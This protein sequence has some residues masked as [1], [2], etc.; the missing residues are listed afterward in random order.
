MEIREL[1]STDLAVSQEFLDEA[2]ATSRIYVKKIYISKR[3]GGTRIVYQPSTKLKT[4]QYW[5]IDRVFKNLPIHEAA[6]AYVKEKSILWNA[7]EH[8]N[9]KYFLKLDFKN[10]FP[11]IKWSDL[12]PIVRKWHKKNTPDWEFSDNAQLLI[13]NTCFYSNDSLPIGYPSSPVIS[14]IVMHDIDKNITQLLS[15]REN[16]GEVI[17]TRYA[18]DIVIS[19]DRRHVCTD[20]LASI[21]ELIGSSDSPK[22]LINKAK[23]RMGSRAGGSALVTGLKICNN[24]ITI[25]KNQKNHI[26][27]LLGLYKKGKLNKKEQ[28]SLLGHIS[29]VQHVAP[30]FY[31]NL[32]SKYLDEI[33]ILK[34]D[35]KT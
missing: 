30:M 31:T 22:L 27:L 10:F 25:H 16:F 6:A 20:I 11:S 7:Y 3:N 29:Y 5:L 13:K 24:H 21:A 33:S 8:R 12:Q 34:S 23:T 28:L 9:S 19:T 17:Y 18:D 26:R 1:I 4:I 35:N 32:Q 14:N 15:D 2:L